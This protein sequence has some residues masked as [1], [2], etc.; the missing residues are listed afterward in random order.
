MSGQYKDRYGIEGKDIKNL[1]ERYQTRIKGDS[2]FESF[3]DFLRWVSESGYRK[4]CRIVKKNENLPHGWDNTTWAENRPKETKKEE[5]A[6]AKAKPD[7]VRDYCSDCE[8]AGAYCSYDGKVGCKEYQENF[9][10]YWNKYI[11]RKVDI[12][13]KKE[14]FRYEHPDLVREGIVFENC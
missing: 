7:A 11:H 5:S 3:D 4:G 10:R 14:F 9:E 1:N 6:E 13:K 8:R 12:P 2:T